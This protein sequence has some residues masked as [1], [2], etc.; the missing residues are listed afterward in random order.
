MKQI[1]WTFIALQ[2]RQIK[3][4]NQNFYKCFALYKLSTDILTNIFVYRIVKPT[5]GKKARNCRI[6]SAIAEHMFAGLP[7]SKLWMEWVLGHFGKP[8]F[9]YF[10]TDFTA[11]DRSLA[12]LCVLGVC[13]DVYQSQ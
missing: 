6:N 4:I 7:V 9:R 1:S 13:Q 10:A 3:A 2:R 12:K 5:S 11:G 8:Y